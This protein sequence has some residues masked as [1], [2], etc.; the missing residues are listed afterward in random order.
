MLVHDQ[1]LQV[2]LSGRLKKQAARQAK[3][4]RMSTSAYVR[5]LLQAD[6]EHGGQLVDKAA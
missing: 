3:K 6:Q 1:I 4:N 2:K 5:A